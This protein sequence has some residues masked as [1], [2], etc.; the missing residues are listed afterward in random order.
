MREGG[1]LIRRNRRA[2]LLAL[3]LA[4][5]SLAA[6]PSN[7]TVR[8]VIWEKLP[9]GSFKLQNG[10]T[11]VP[12]TDTPR[13]A[14]GSAALGVGAEVEVT[15]KFDRESQRLWAERIVLRTDFARVLEG[16]AVVEGQ[17]RVADGF[18]LSA[19]GRRLHL[20]N[21][22]R[23]LAPADK[24]LKAISSLDAIQSGQPIRYRG[25]G[26]EGGWVDVTELSAWENDLGEKEQG[27]YEK[28]EP[29]ILLPRKQNQPTIL[30]VDVNRYELL[31]DKPLQL[32]IDRLGTGLLPGSS[33]KDEN[34][35]RQFWFFLVAHERPQASAFPSG[36]VVVHTG[37][38]RVAEN[39]AQLAF[40]LAHEIAHVVEEHAWREY[41]YHR[42]KLLALRWGTAGIG[43]TVE[44]AIRRG[45]DRKLEEQADRLAL[46][47]MIQAGY[48]PRE[49]IRFLKRLQEA[50]LRLP[51]LLWDTHKSSGRRRQALLE[52]L[53][54]H[55][56]GGVDCNSLVRD[57]PG[58]AQVREQ[59][60]QATREGGQGASSPP[61]Q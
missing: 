30:Q 34:A 58:F 47:Y 16:T 31:T 5:P 32:F 61:K 21:R 60:L 33:K 8:D 53:A 26:T 45:Y 29:A 52:E 18:L 40:A 55:S 28:Y 14:D 54:A 46:W 25:V 57:T 12:S 39:E 13:L 36:V 1:F 56:A 51:G 4:A 20:T 23:L 15:G 41:R 9:D 49:G 42:R 10:I 35:R 19:D 38:L 50:Q 48:D 17:Q 59:L 2:V 27:L 44:S 22:T 11:V 43:Y 37:L 6:A 3:L 24:E 7:R